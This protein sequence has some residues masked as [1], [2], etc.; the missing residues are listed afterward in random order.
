MK[1]L[2]TGA[3]GRIGGLLAERLPDLGWDVTGCDITS[4]WAHGDITDLAGMETLCAGQQVVMHL[5]GAPNAKRGWRHVSRL[6][7]EGTRCVLEASLRAGVRRVV[8][9]SSIHVV[10]GLPW[11]T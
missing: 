10:G 2:I 8:Y 11:G 6:N 3:A 4:D 5:A 9:A 7:I 1:V